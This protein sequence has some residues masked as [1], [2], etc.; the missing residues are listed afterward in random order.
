MAP[1]ADE[2]SSEANI[3]CKNTINGVSG[4]RSKDDTAYYT[5]NALCGELLGSI[6]TKKYFTEKEK[7]DVTSMIGEIMQ[8]YR[9][10]LSGADWLSEQTRAT[11]IGKLDAMKIR[12]GY[13]EKYRIDWDNVDVSAS[14]PFI[15]NV[16]TVMQEQRKM[17][18]SLDG[19]KVDSGV[20]D[21]MNANTVNAF[22]DSSDNSINFPA[23]ILN[24]PMYDASRSHS[25]NLGA[26]G[27]VIAHEIT[28]AFDSS[29]S[30]FDKDGNMTDW[31]TESDRA[32]FD[33]RTDKVA[34]Y[35]SSIEIMDGLCINGE[36]TKGETVADLGSMACTLD[37]MRGMKDADYK[38]YFTAYANLWKEKIT[39]EAQESYA[40]TNPHPP[41]YMRFN[42]TVMQYQEFYDTFGIKEGDKMYI[43]PEDRLK[44][45]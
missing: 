35:Y 45:W 21:N 15:E 23:A 5:E 12:V 44:V 32:A 40:M 18:L 17:N 22:Y 28:H 24:D 9:I 20:W 25:Y 14:K 39:P 7:Q 30:Q 41:T 2:F 43:A 36:L 10:R 6:Y 29:G 13:P 31:W 26:I 11:A 27:N 34:K 42:V 1:Y 4:R 33:D 38:E 3:T 19:K 16:I 8:D 37:I